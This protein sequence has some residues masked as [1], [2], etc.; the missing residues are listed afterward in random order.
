EIGRG[1]RPDLFNLGYV[2]PEPFVERALR[3]EVTERTSY[4]GEVETAPAL[5]EVPGIVE[6]LQ[7]EKVEAVAVCCL[8]T[9]RNPSNEAAI[10]SELRRLWPQGTVVASHEVTREWREFERSCT[11]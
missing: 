11:T 5:E 8:H 9:Y 10:A 1:N 2:K 7:R 3:F 4:T 6:A